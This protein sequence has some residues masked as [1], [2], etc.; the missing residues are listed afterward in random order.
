[1]RASIV[2]SCLAALL[3]SAA[4]GREEPAWSAARREGTRAAYADYMNRFP[5]GEHA[6]E[7]RA[8]I[9]ALEDD[10]A[11]AR[12]ERIG[13]PEAWQRYIGDW[14][15]GRHVLLAQQLLVGFIPPETPAPVAPRAGAPPTDA[16]DAAT[17]AGGAPL[18]GAFE[19]QLGAW[20]DEAAAREALAAWQDGRAALLEGYGVRLAAPFG[21]GPALWRLRTAPLA[22]AEARALCERI[23]GAGADCVPAIA[24]S[25]GDPPP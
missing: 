19:V 6:G 3:A 17:A 5:A 25:A 9:R 12:A 16:A 22:E 10:E 20:R 1:M 8:A 24:I 13:T 11:W 23:K 4:C 2:A 15:E 7:A 14:P 18:P 21:E